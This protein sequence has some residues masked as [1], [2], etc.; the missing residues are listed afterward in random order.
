VYKVVTLDR[1]FLTLRFR[2]SV[3]LRRL[4]LKYVYRE[5]IE[6]VIRQEFCPYPNKV[7]FSIS[8]IGPDKKWI[9]CAMPESAI[10][11]V[12]TWIHEFVENTIGNF[13]LGMHISGR[14]CFKD[15]PESVMDKHFITCLSTYSSVFDDG[16]YRVIEPDEFI[17]LFNIFDCDFTEEVVT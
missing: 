7:C 6:G 13:L 12:E 5:C 15:M 3:K 9:A 1:R 16:T 4:V 10:P 14:V 2:L 11:F 8:E 17:S